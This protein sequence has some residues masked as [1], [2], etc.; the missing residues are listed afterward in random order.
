MVI[1]MKNWVERLLSTRGFHGKGSLFFLYATIHYIGLMSLSKMYDQQ[2]NDLCETARVDYLSPQLSKLGIQVKHANV[3]NNTADHPKPCGHIYLKWLSCSFY[4]DQQKSPIAA[5][6]YS[7]PFL[8]I[9]G[10]SSV[11]MTNSE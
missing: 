8:K 10:G 4:L 7:N 3:N 11:V 9:K 5:K 1:W 2:A 6:L